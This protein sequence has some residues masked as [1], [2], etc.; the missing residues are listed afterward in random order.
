MGISF[1]RVVVPPRMTQETTRF[2][3]E[4]SAHSYRQSLIAAL[5]VVRTIQKTGL[6]GSYKQFSQNCL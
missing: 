3:R 1:S 6:Q 5:Q 2:K 4:R